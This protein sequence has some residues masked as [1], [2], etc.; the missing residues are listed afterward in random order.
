MKLRSRQTEAKRQL[1]RNIQASEKY[2]KRE[3]PD[4]NFISDIAQLRPKNKYAKGLIIP[5]FL[6]KKNPCREAGLAG[7]DVI[8][9]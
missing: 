9:Y 4:E 5:A 2:V 8:E 1:V 6:G 7:H 3:Y